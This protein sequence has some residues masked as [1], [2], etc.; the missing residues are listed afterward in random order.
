MHGTSGRAAVLADD[1]RPSLTAHPAL[2][3]THLGSLCSLHRHFG[4]ISSVTFGTL[5]QVLQINIMDMILF[6]ILENSQSR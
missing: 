2:A 3:G 5:P 1:M 4:S 6:L